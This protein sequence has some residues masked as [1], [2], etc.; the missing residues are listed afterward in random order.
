MDIS[1][2]SL[3]QPVSFYNKN[4]GNSIN[5]AINEDN[6]LYGSNFF[7]PE[8]ALKETS[9]L[10]TLPMKKKRKSKRLN[11]ID[12]DYLPD[13]ASSSVKK[14]SEA[15][16]FF[17]EEK[18]NVISKF[19]KAI[20]HFVTVTPLI[21]YFFLKQKTK[22]IQQTVESLNNISQN[23]DDL[24]NTTIPYGEETS[25]YTDLA[26]NLTDA[27]SILGKANKDF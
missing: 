3:N 26:K 2:N 8:F 5:M 24:M 16:N 1:S 22:K 12:S 4:T 21:N 9:K 19:Q 17:L 23:V 27:A 10:T 11:T 25:L 14:D 18:P 13:E 6:Q 7:S 20:E 15:N